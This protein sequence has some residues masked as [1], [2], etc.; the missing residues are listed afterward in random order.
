MLGNFLKAAGTALI[1]NDW[2]WN[3][4]LVLPV[5][6]RPDPPTNELHVAFQMILLLA[7]VHE[8]TTEPI[9]PIS[10]PANKPRTKPKPPPH[11]RTCNRYFIASSATCHHVSGATW[12]GST[13]IV[14]GTTTGATSQ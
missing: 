5:C 13:V 11:N 12:Q 8:P 6:P 14:T 2:H 1:A 7:R 9:E 3:N 10:E 4:N